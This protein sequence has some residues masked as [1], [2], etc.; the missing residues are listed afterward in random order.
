ME[1]HSSY[2]SAG[3]LQAICLLSYSLSHQITIQST[4]S[5]CQTTSRQ[6][7]EVDTQDPALHTAPNPIRTTRLFDSE[8]AQERGQPA[9]MALNLT[10]E[11]PPHNTAAFLS[12]TNPHHDI[13]LVPHP[14]R[15]TPTPRLTFL[16]ES[17]A[18]L[19]DLLI[20]DPCTS[21]SPRPAME[22]A[23]RVSQVSSCQQASEPLKTEMEKRRPQ[24]THMRARLDNQIIHQIRQTMLPRRSKV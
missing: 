2:K 19:L 11:I 13:C 3:K 8:R 12:H 24:A 10:L 20:S 4:N 23:L 18:T 5:S 15:P 21:S 6:T 14:P 9:P 1:A 7:S 17:P 22:A 16:P